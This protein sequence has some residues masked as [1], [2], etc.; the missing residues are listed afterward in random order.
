MNLHEL[1]EQKSLELKEKTKD[2]NALIQNIPG[3]VMCC[4]YTREL[5]LLFISD[6]FLKMTGYTRKEI[7]ER[8]QNEFSR[9]IYPEDLEK[10]WDKVEKQLA[11]RDQKEIEYRII[12]RDGKL[13]YVH[14]KG[15]VVNREDGS[16]VFYCILTDIDHM[17]KES[18]KLREQAQRDA[19]TGLYNK[20][21]VQNL[22]EEKLLHMQ[23]GEQG[24]FFIIDIDNFK[25]INDVFGHLNGDVMLAEAGRSLKKL[26]RSNDIVGRVG[27]DEF[28]VLLWGIQK[29]EDAEKK[30]KAILDAF[31]KLMNKEMDKQQISCSIGIARIP[32]DGRTFQDIFKNA[33]VALYYAKK[34]GKNRYAVYDK[35]MPPQSLTAAEL[36]SFAASG[37]KE[38][39][40]DKNLGVLPYQLAE[41]VFH[42]LYNGDNLEES[43]PLILEIVGR[44]M[45]VSRVYIFEDSEDGTY[46]TNTFEWCSEGIAPQ[47]EFL[48]KVPYAVLGDYY[49]N[50]D[51]YGIY[52]CRNIRE[53][54]KEQFEILDAQ[55]IKSML[56]CL[57]RDGGKNRGYVGF[58]ECRENRFWPQAQIKTLALI[59]EMVG[60]FLLKKR[61]QDRKEQLL[62][63][64]HMIL[65]NQEEWIYAV[66]RNTYKIQY[67]NLAT[68]EAVREAAE[69]SICYKAFYCR[70]TPCEYCP[71][72]RLKRGGK[73]V[74]GVLYS[75]VLGKKV[76]ATAA[77]IPWL[78]QK[79]VFLMSCRDMS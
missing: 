22:T 52:Y 19:L 24:A 31:G 14:D 30:A 54:T 27:G 20:I 2:M 69:G 33:D 70:D 60:T 66:E 43:I 58:D 45:D 57:I 67:A 72:L 55:G 9:M 48:Q 34:K 15:Q 71:S 6:G 46:C 78:D 51:E 44:Q 16:Q 76:M 74:S 8:F 26:V 56:H 79:E 77:A 13:L 11:H 21:T 12:C 3:G 64:L 36:K 1:V 28:A 75:E 68:R 53:M 35:G 4:E 50:F 65:D 63:S 39:E 7:A 32:G 41:Y 62:D 17:K 59:S 47:K 37:E 49:D 42:I 73:K 5:K 61:A 38:I 29:T 25:Q 18:L 40:S 23:E 10:T